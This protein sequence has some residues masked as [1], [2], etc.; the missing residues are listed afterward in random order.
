MR[1]LIK[2]I[3]K[4]ETK[5]KI[6]LCGKLNVNSK[7]EIIDLLNDEVISPEQEKEIKKILFKL[8][9]DLKRLPNK[10]DTL[11]TYF[12]DIQSVICRK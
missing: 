2:K 10:L 8:N 7:E 12:H 5:D 1:H 11:D 6:S 3:L 4:E 9:D